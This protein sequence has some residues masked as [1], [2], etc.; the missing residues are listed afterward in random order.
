ME[1]VFEFV[2]KHWEFLSAVL[3]V[4]L[5]W[6][7]VKQKFHERLEH[8]KE[9][10]LAAKNW[11]KS[12]DLYKAAKTAYGVVSK[13]SRKTE[14]T[15]DDKAARGLEEAMRLMEHLGWDKSELGNGE[16]D[17]I[18]KVFDELH[19]NEHLQLEAAHGM[20]VSN[21]ASMPGQV[22]APLAVGSES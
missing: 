7:D 13:L 11:A 2:S 3:G 12:K 9:K 20:P 19:E 10:Y 16:K 6:M 1:Q 15:M 22:A 8:S 14:N 5:G 17:V 4:V 18:L 21:K